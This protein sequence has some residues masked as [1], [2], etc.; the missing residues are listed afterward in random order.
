[1]HIKSFKGS[2]VRDAI[3]AVKAELGSSALIINTKRLSTGLYEVIAA[4]DYDLTRPVDLTIPFSRSGGPSS[5]PSGDAGPG[6]LDGN[7]G[8][9][10]R[11]GAENRTACAENDISKF[12]AEL[13]E[14]RELKDFCRDIAAQAAAEHSTTYK[15]IEEELMANGVDKR[16][17]RKML[18]S[19]FNGA[20]KNKSDDEGAVKSCMRQK[21]LERID[22]EDPL[23]KKAP[24]AFVG[25]AG[26]G[27]TTTIAKLAAVQ[28]LKKKKRVAL[29]SMDTHR[30]AATEQLKVFGRIIG[31]PVDVART[32]EELASLIACHGDKDNILID[33]AGRSQRSAAH[34]KELFALAS[35][36][37][38][39]RFNLVLSAQTRDQALYDSIKGF[40][41]VPYDTL[42][43]TKLDEGASYGQM[44]NT[45]I[46]AKKPVAYLSAGQRVPDDIELA[47]RERLLNLF[48]PN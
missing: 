37:P 26:V 4:V 24:I 40:S 14:L 13:D 31:V 35:L 38:G 21:I 1:M 30:I 44:L 41:A 8:T 15:K 25:P 19:A 36:T 9:E 39:L 17:A 3:K 32:P 29:L 48:M 16:L 43:F 47:S 11:T 27:K 34:M 7:D 18:V 5:P 46:L 33:T 12:G 10:Q 28:A 42:T 45:A 22:V 20:G 6:G 23:D 2:T